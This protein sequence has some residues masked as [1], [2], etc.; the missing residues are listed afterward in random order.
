MV[1]RTAPRKHDR[2][3]YARPLIRAATV[4][5]FPPTWRHPA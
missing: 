3:R 4:A 5:L 2:T 1:T